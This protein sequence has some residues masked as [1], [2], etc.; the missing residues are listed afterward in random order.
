MF[1][2]VKSAIFWT[3]VYKFRKRLT[4]VVLLLSTVL[5]SQ[6]IYAD[7]IEYLKLTEK[8]QYLDYILPIKWFVILLNICVSAY[9]LLTL[10]KQN[11]TVSKE[12]D[13]KLEKQKIYKETKQKSNSK[14]SDR[15]KK[16]LNKKLRSEA[17]VLM[18][19]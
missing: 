11:N 9:I 18:D 8:T 19:R 17:E 7:I 6:W 3:L 16:F 4:L 1:R 15:E 5:L 13:E 2:Q 12:A 14:F 10:F